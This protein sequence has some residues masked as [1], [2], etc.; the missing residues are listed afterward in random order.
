VDVLI[1]AISSIKNNIENIQCNI[2]GIGPE[3]KKLKGMVQ[4]LDLD[5][6]VNFLG[7]IKRHDD[8]IKIIKK[9]HVFC[10]PSIVEGFG[11]VVIEAMAC[12][13]PYV[14]SNIPPLKEVTNNG[15][16]GLLF[17]RENPHDLAKKIL[18]LL[19]DNDLYNKCI[20]EGLKLAQR[21]DWINIA[22]ETEMFYNKMRNDLSL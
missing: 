20:H 14:C 5:G 3:S 8:V 1:K 17:E 16:G 2:V 12:S 9:S 18:V 6:N 11:I 21:Y 19:K 4:K 15:M 22:K 10:L 13:T 7:F